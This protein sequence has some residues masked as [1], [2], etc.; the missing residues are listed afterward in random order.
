MNRPGIIV[1]IVALIIGLL[2]GYLWWGTPLQR[3]QSE[4]ADTRARVEVLEAQAAE[5]RTDPA[6]PDVVKAQQAQI[7]ELEQDLAV[8]RQMRGRLELL[9]SQGKK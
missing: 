3:Q 7:R 6:R 2:A 4:L 5:R 1:G 9:I 8:E